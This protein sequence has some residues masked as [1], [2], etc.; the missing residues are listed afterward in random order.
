MSCKSG[1]SPANNFRDN[2]NEV[3]IIH[4]A[5]NYKNFVSKNTFDTVSSIHNSIKNGKTN[6]DL[7]I[8]LLNNN[9]NLGLGLLN[10]SNTEDAKNENPNIDV[11]NKSNLYK[12]LLETAATQK[13]DGL[14]N[15]K[16]ARHPSN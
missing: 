1:S 10:N 5:N 14:L 11:L 16:K 4:L 15:K 9:S 13:D 2:N 8:G 12:V 7:H 3:E 6:D